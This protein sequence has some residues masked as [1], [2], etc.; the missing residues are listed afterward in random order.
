MATLD[1]LLRII[2]IFDGKKDHNIKLYLQ[3]FQEAADQIKLADTIKLTILKSKFTGSAHVQVD[4][5]LNSENDYGKFKEKLIE[6]FGPKITFN[7]AHKIFAKLKQ[8][9]DKS[10][11]D[12]IVR[13]NLNIAKFL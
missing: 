5:E 7:D 1:S 9:P 13:F 11:N 10:M 6:M 2:P 3:Q 4:T 8:N 12:F